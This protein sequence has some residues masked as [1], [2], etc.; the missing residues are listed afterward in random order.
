MKTVVG[1]PNNITNDIIGRITL[2]HIPF[3]KRKD[4][5]YV[6]KTNT[7]RSH[8]Y[9]G[10]VTASPNTL[11]SAGI[12]CNPEDIGV[13]NDGDVVLINMK[14]EIVFLY[15]KSSKHNALF[16]TERCNH[17]CIMCP[18]PPVAQEIDK[19]EMNLRILSLIDNG[20]ESIGLTGG[21]PTLIGDNLF[22]VIKYINHRFPKTYITLL[23]NCVKFSNNDYARKLAACAKKTLQID[24]PIFSDIPELHNEIVGAS[25]FYKTVQG[26]YNLA[27]YHINI[28]LRIVIHKKTYKRLVDLANYIYRN[29]PFVTQVAFMQL[30]TTG[31]A[32]RS[33]EDLW[34]D[35]FDYN[36]ELQEAVFLLSERGIPA[37]IYNAQ[38]CV[39]P[40]ALREYSCNS[41]S[42]W[43][44]VYLPVCESCRLKNQ[45]GGL[46]ESNLNYHSK[47]IAPITDED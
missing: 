34:I 1:K 8:K 43:K 28:G 46:F 3:W 37:R 2:K 13:F 44:D 42:D 22:Q 29:F 26:L 17:R 24:V 35:P 7:K 16:L 41:I 27:T 4:A 32:E 40:K 31:M 14:G 47:H 38:L 10:I 5:I 21:E 33:I 30:E 18:Q 36:N 45:C 20:I 23:S 39:L 9:L 6:S 19:T 11:N 12:V 15:E 25:T